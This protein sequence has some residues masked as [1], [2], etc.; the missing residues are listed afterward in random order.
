MDESPA[1]GPAMKMC[2]IRT[3]NQTAEISIHAWALSCHGVYTLKDKK[4]LFKI[5][6]DV[7]PSVR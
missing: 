3:S 1:S 2:F 4:L 5:P 6:S 7:V